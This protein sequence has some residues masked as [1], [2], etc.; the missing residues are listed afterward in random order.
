MA[1]SFL[2]H[3][4]TIGLPWVSPRFTIDLSVYL[5]GIGMKQLQ[6]CKQ[7]NHQQLNSSLIATSY[8]YYGYTHIH[9]YLKGVSKIQGEIN[10]I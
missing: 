5:H 1:N 6:Y 9:N 3:A 4:V 10:R 2:N 8:Q 7:I